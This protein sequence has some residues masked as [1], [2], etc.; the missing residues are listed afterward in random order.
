MLRSIF[1]ACPVFEL[2]FGGARGGGK[3]DGVLGDFLEHAATYGKHAT[4]LMVRRKRVELVET[5]ERSRQIYGPLGWKYSEQKSMWTARNGARL[6]FGYLE[7]DADADNYHGHSYTRLYVEEITNFPS[8][9]PI[10]KLMA[11]LRSAH[12][13]P[14]GFRATGNPGGPGHHW[15]RRRYVDPAP[16]GG[17]IITDE[18]SGLQRVFIQSK[19]ADNK[20]L[21]VDYIQRIKA[22]GGE[23]LERAWLHGDWSVIEGAFFSEWTSD[24]IIAPFTIPSHWTRL[25]TMDFGYA[26]PS[27]IYWLAVVGDTTHHDGRELPRGALIA[28]REWYTSNGQPN[29]GLRL[30]AEE[31]ARSIVLREAGETITRGVLDPSAFAADGGPSIAERMNRILLAADHTPFIPADNRRTPQAGHLGGW[32]QMRQRLKAKQLFFFSTCTEASGPS[33]SCNMTTTSP[34]TLTR[35]ARTTQRMPSDM[36]AWPG[37]TPA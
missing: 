16:Q 31:I 13:V 37:H 6:R 26:V 4:G 15:V 17:K 32:D 11:T 1:L 27:A 29:V 9:K 25:R 23:A 28:H 22:S 3:T 2:F 18:K 30:T 21:G 14:V 34:R 19:V 20:Y 7:R 33:R 10:L 12:G 24:C 5:I 8:D 36:A 35:A